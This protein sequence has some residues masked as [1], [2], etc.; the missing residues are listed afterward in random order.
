VYIENMIYVIGVDHLKEQIPNAMNE[1]EKVERL[2]TFVRKTCGE[3]NI[4]LIAE[5]WCEDARPRSLTRRTHTEAVASELGIKYSPCDP[6]IAERKA[7]G[8]KARDQIALEIGVPFPL[9]EDTLEERANAA[10]INAAARKYD[11][12][13]EEYWLRE[14]FK[15][16]D[17]STPIL[18]VCGYGH[19]DDF[20]KLAKNKGY[21]AEKIVIH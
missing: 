7:M 19:V 11:E 6:G 2:R 13:R 5:E 20:I 17:A 9:T 1:S 10:K 3:K 12:I 8:F 4:Q 18:L 15:N 14:I 21:E 16:G